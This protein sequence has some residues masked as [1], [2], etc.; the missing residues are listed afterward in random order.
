MCVWEN[1]KW[2]LI[3]ELSETL[4]LTT[5]KE[6]LLM[7]DC[8][9]IL[10]T[11]GWLLSLWCWLW[12]RVRQT[13]RY[14]IATVMGQRE[15]RP[16]YQLTAPLLSFRSLVHSYIGLSSTVWHILPFVSLVSATQNIVNDVNMPVGWFF[17]FP[18]VLQ[19][20]SKLPW[21]AILCIPAFSVKCSYPSFCQFVMI[22]LP[23]DKP[24]AIVFPL[25]S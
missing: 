1:K 3:W 18:P 23:G 5:N 8:R 21:S 11:P 10:R 4:S 2:T 7:H 24:T 6:G 16:S 17:P 15:E 14:V 12:R 22:L 20:W 25:V 9:G 13:R 19:R